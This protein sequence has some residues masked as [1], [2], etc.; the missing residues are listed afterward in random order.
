MRIHR[1]G[2]VSILT[3][4][5]KLVLGAP[6][7]EFRSMIADLLKAANQMI[8]LNFR[9][10]A[11]ADNVGIGALA[12]NFSNTKAAGGRLVVAEA[13]PNV[14]EIMHVTRLSELIP[15]FATEQEAISSFC[16]CSG[17]TTQISK[18]NHWEDASLVQDTRHEVRGASSGNI[19]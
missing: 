14:R 3:L 13:Q 11:Y 7:H 8:V 6:S 12:F 19:P 10:V 1:S 18:R 2:T 17:R 4:A 15:V 16:V 9:G 5:G